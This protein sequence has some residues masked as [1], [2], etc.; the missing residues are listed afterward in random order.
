MGEHLRFKPG[1]CTADDDRLESIRDLLAAAKE[2]AEQAEWTDDP[3]RFRLRQEYE[4]LR[5]RY[6]NGEEFAP[7]F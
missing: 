5:E 2:R 6:G 4:D 3:N 7:K 1:A